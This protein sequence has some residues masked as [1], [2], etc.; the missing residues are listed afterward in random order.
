MRVESIE[1]A[2]WVGMTRARLVLADPR[3][4]L[5]VGLVVL[6]LLDVFTTAL[7]LDRGGEERNPFVEPFVDDMWQVGA[8]KGLTLAVIATLLTRCRGSRLAELALTAT[9]GWYLAVVSWNVAVLTFF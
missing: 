6:N 5:F 3:W 8:M 1:R 4:S 2:D 7:V 9:T